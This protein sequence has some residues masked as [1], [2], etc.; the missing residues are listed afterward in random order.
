MLGTYAVSAYNMVVMFQE[1]P[2]G[3][4]KTTNVQSAAKFASLVAICP[5]TG[6][7]VSFYVGKTKDNVLFDCKAGKYQIVK[8]EKHEGTYKNGKSF[9]VIAE[10]V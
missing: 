9:F 3:K 10:P 4:Y 5:E 6:Q 2:E 7:S 1:T 8:I